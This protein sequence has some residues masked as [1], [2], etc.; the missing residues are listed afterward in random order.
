M[1]EALIRA[2]IKSILEGVSGIGVVYDYERYARSLAD[3]FDLMTKTG[4]TTVNGWIIHRE[5]TE[6]RQATMGVRGQ[7]DRVHTFRIAGLHEMNDDDGSE[8]T[9]QGIID[10]IFAAFKANPTLNET[11]L[12]HG[13]IQVEEVTV[14]LEEEYGGDL[15]HVADCTLVVEERVNVTT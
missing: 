11:A 2:Q 13:Q 10:A 9:F 7:I 6:S 8:K 12:S 4:T 3:Y 14:C 5:R 1:S 15:Y